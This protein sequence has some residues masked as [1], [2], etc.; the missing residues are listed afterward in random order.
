MANAFFIYHISR[1]KIYH[2][3][4]YYGI[5]VKLALKLLGILLSEDDFNP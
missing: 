5:F 2:Y 3:L 1:S 4:P